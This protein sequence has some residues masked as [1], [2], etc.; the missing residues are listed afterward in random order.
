MTMRILKT[1]TQHGIRTFTVSSMTD[2]RRRYTVTRKTA[3]K[4]ACSCPA[5][6]YP[7]CQNCGKTRRRCKCKAPAIGRHDCKHIKQIRRAA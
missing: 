2:A 5:W 3:R 1:R 6:I 7:R 4:W